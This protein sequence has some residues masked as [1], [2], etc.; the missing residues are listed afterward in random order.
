MTAAMLPGLAAVAALVFT[1]VSVTQVSEELTI[2]QQGQ[3]A[4]RYDRALERLN[5]N[6]ATIRRGAVF[7]LQGIMEDAP[8]QQPSVID[9]LSAYVRAHAT[10]KLSTPE[11]APDVQA[12]LFVL[13][14]R[15]PAHD[16]GA[17]L[18]LRDVYLTGALLQGADLTRANLTGAVLTNADLEGADLSGATLRRATLKQ[19][20]LPDATLAGADLTAATLTEANLRGANLTDARLGSA[21]LRSTTL[22]HADLRN[23]YLN[24]ADLRQADLTD[25]DFAGAYLYG[26]NLAG[27]E[28]EAARLDD[29]VL[30]KVNRPEGL[31]TPESPLPTTAPPTSRTDPRSTH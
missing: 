27:A 10:K 19:T 15:D 14:H 22:T 8:R 5:N 3:I 2:S 17:P 1:W 25:A 23:A 29:A 9:A 24:K 4:D 26:A 21:D 20:E 13:T 7:S 18:D 28:L 30:T 11:K 31:P 6:S 12:A 16:G